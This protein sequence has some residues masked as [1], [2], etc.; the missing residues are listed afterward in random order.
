MA[1]ITRGFGSRSHDR[2]TRLPPGQ[3]QVEDWP[4]LTAGATPDIDPEIWEFTVTTED[5]TTTRSLPGT[6]RYSSGDVAVTIP[7]SRLIRGTRGTIVQAWT[8]NESSAGV[9]ETAST[10]LAAAARP[11]ASARPPDRS[12]TTITCRP[13]RPFGIREPSLGS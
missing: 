1:L 10:P 12:R 7:P 4:V 8:R 3:T 5:G 13:V 9:L 11:S 2:D 6:C